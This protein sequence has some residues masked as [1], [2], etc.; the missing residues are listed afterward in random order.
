MAQTDEQSTLS[1]SIAHHGAYVWETKL[2]LETY[3]EVQSYDSVYEFVTEDNILNKSSETYR[4][5]ILREI[6]RR[7][8]I[9]KDGY[10]E[11]PLVN[12]LSSD[13]PDATKE[14]ILYYEFSADPLVR[15]LTV[16]FLYPL[17]SSGTLTV[18]NDDVVDFLDDLES[19]YSEIGEWSAETKKRVGQHYLAAMKNFEILEGS[20]TKEFAYIY[21]PEQAVAYVLYAL[22]DEGVSAAEA[23]VSHN[24]WKL[25]FLSTEDVRRRLQDL[26]PEFLRYEK[27]GTV[28]RMDPKYESLM[29][30]VNEF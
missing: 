12:V 14:W 27:R 21:P 7:Y 25:L 9:D 4:K 22:L 29:E 5:K 28:E 26:S 24:D 23:N 10:S 6:A 18:T 16:E 15:L 2:I 1:S 8:S 3:A 30:C 17:Y 13:L 20:S 19:E 11:T